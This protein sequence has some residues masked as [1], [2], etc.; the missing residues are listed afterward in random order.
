MTIISQETVSGTPSQIYYKK[1]AGGHDAVT[2]QFPFVVNILEDGKSICG[3]TLISDRWI[4]TA[5]HCLFNPKQLAIKGETDEGS[6]FGWGKTT[7]EE[8]PSSLQQVDLYAASERTC[9][10]AN[11]RLSQFTNQYLCVGLGD[12]KD[13]CIGDS[14]G[15]LL[16]RNQGQWIQVG[17][18]SYG[19]DSSGNDEC[20]RHGT[21]GFYARVSYGLPWIL[22]TTGLSGRQISVEI[23]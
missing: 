9:K 20:G 7:T 6:D 23:N 14:G 2:G 8:Y 5:A 13:T 12:G 21:F 18:T 16:V 22:A 4:L 3:G 15:P 17:I 19:D 1:I 11:T 10:M